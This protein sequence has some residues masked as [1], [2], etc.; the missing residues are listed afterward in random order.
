MDFTQRLYAA[1]AKVGGMLVDATLTPVG[2]ESVALKVGYA[3]ATE[4]VLGDVIATVPAI[5]F[6]TAALAALK[7]GDAVQV[8]GQAWTVRAVERLG[9]GSETKAALRRG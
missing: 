9:D 3:A 7:P 2:G 6:P 5:K 1:A 4:M 8:A